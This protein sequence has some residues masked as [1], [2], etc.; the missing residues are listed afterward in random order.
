MMINLKI[1]FEIND[2]VTKERIDNMKNGIQR[3]INKLNN[4]A[5]FWG[6]IMKPD[7]LETEFYNYLVKTVTTT[8]NSG[9]ILVPKEWIGKKVKILLVEP[10]GD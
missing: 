7:K 8:G 2:N 9:H 1:K 4:N 6:L 3:S 5:K 10:L